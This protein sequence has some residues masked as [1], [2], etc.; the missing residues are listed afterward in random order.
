MRTRELR[1][2]AAGQSPWVATALLLAVNVVT[3]AYRLAVDYHGLLDVGLA[4]A[5]FW[6]IA[7]H[8]RGPRLKPGERIVSDREYHASEMA[9]TRAVLAGQGGRGDGSGRKLQSVI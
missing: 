4:L 3:C 8:Y 7:R 2:L 1:D 9:I 6:G 5:A